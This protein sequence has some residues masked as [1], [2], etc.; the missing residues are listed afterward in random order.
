MNRTKRLTLTGIFAGLG[1]ALMFLEFPIFPQATFLKY[2]PSDIPALILTLNLG[3][4]AGITVVLVKDILF[5]FAK[6]GDIVGIAMNALAGI[7]FVSLSK[8]FWSTTFK[9]RLIASVIVGSGVTTVMLG[10]N[11]IVVP[12][13]F[14]APFDVF[15][16]FLPFI[17]AF[18]LVKFIVDFHVGALIDDRLRFV[19]RLG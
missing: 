11:A 2:D 17:I 5:Y 6:S 16:K 19:L 15:L 18:N 13:Y 4:T 8:L 3:Y 10:A 9:S 7:V 1:F 14:K 12:M